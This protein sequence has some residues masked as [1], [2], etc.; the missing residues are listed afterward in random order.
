MGV[1][2]VDWDRKRVWVRVP[3]WIDPSQLQRVHHGPPAI[4]AGLGLLVWGLLDL[5][6]FSVWFVRGPQS[7]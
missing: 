6:D 3:R 7:D 4:L 5:H 2:R 1:V